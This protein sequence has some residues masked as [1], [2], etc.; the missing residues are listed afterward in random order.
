MQPTYISLDKTFGPTEHH[1]V[2]LFQRP[3]VWTKEENWEPLWVDIAGLANRVLA[4]PQRIRAHFLGTIVLEQV[5]TTVG[6]IYTREIIDGQ[7][8]LTTLQILLKAACHALA[9]IERQS[10]VADNA[11]RAKV[12][13]AVASRIATLTVNQGYEDDERYK[14]WPTNEDRIPFRQVMNAESA[15]ELVG[16]STRMA[17]AYRHFHSAISSWLFDDLIEQRIQ[18][19]DAALREHLKLIALDLEKDD[20]P[21]AIFQLS[22]A[23]GTPLLPSDLIKNFT[24]GGVTQ[25]YYRSNLFTKIIGPHSIMT[26]CIGGSK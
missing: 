16:I 23:H 18:A 8:R 12:A 4:N 10:L 17:D 20:E 13:R 25:K 9:E 24:M 15:A 2:P 7:Q 6:T 21:Q 22:N 11:A 3:Y 19:L 1:L 14:V 5:A 26:I